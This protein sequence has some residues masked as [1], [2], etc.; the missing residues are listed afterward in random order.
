MKNAWLSFQ[1]YFERLRK[2]P[3]RWGKPFA[4]LLG[5]FEAQLALGLGAIGGKDSMSGSFED[6]DVPPTLISFVASATKADNVISPEFKRNDTSL[7]LIQPE[8]D[9]NGLYNKESLVK[10]FK[11]VQKAIEDKRILSAYAVGVGGIAE[12][13]TKMAFGNKI[14]AKLVNT[15]SQ[16]ELFE[17]KY[18]AFVVETDGVL[19]FGKKIGV[20]TKDYNIYV[21]GNILSIEKLEKLWAETLEPVYPTTGGEENKI[22]ENL[23]YKAE[24]VLSP[25]VKAPQPSVLIPVFPGTNCEYDTARAFEKYG[26]KTEIFVVRNRTPEEVQESA[27]RLARAIK[28]SHIVA[29]PGG[30]SGGDEPDGSAKF[31]VSLLRN[32]RVAKEIR[33][34]LGKRDGLMCGICNGFQALVKLGLVPY[35]KIVEPNENNPTLTF[36]TI[37]RH[38][39][40]LVH[41]RIAS[42]KS[43]WLMHTNV[44][45]IHTIAISHGE[46]RFIVNEKELKKL[47]KNGQIA[48]QYVDLNGNATSDI[49]FNP[50]NSV[51]AIEGITSPDG[52]VFGKMG[53]TE[54]NGLHLYKNVPDTQEQLIFKGA[55][56]YYK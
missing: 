1:E 33:A 45:D 38:Q 54:R 12:A 11:N 22:Y 17:K 25:L 28:N 23:S 3:K 48:T 50:N 41:T 32:P 6:I 43:P 4:A 26:A 56:D 35:G 27:K 34:L 20:T 10:T 49:L 40:R 24:K 7:Y 47:I 14:G 9:E 53:H 15:L 46:G 42:N 16:D 37:G 8:K 39:S 44:G 52:R 18:G 51:M 31:I 5:G 13:V 36:N 29:L 30:F 2:D 55:V 19:R 21:H